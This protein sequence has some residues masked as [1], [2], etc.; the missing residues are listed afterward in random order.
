MSLVKVANYIINGEPG[1]TVR[2]WGF[3]FII[4]K[5]MDAICDMPEEYVDDMVNAGRI[6]RVFPDDYVNTNQVAN[7]LLETFNGPAEKL[8][9]FSNMNAFRRAM[10]KMP[11]ENLLVL[12][13]KK[14]GVIISP[15]TGKL[16]IMNE[17]TKHVHYLM[18]K[19]N[20]E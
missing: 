3:N 20:K 14:L 9:G 16:D 1:Q 5:N 8:F 12:A 7:E 19:A 4:Q 18:T 15:R 11:K 2:A 17:I 10:R 13:D 6:V